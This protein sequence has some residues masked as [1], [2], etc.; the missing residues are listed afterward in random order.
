MSE[1][2]KPVILVAL[3]VTFFAQVALADGDRLVIQVRTDATPGVHFDSI[4]SVLFDTDGSTVLDTEDHTAASARDYG[5]GVRV[6]EFLFGSGIDS[7][8]YFGQTSLQ[9]FGGTVVQRP[10]RV[11]LLPRHGHAVT[12]HN[13]T[14]HVATILL[15]LFFAPVEL[16]VKVVTLKEDNDTSGT[17]SPGDVLEY[18][19]SFTTSHALGRGSVLRDEPA[20]HA[21]LIPGTVTTSHG[22]VFRGNLPS[23]TDVEARFGPVPTGQLVFVKYRVSVSCLSP[24]IINQG[25]LTLKLAGD[26]A[27]Y[28]LLTDDLFTP[29]VNDPTVVPVDCGLP[30]PLPGPPVPVVSPQVSP[31]HAMSS[32]IIE[33]EGLGTLSGPPMFTVNG[34]SVETEVLPSFEQKEFVAALLTSD[35]TEGAGVIP[36]TLTPADPQLPKVHGLIEIRLALE[37][38]KEILQQLSETIADHIDHGLGERVAAFQ[39]TRS[40]AHMDPNSCQPL[41]A[42]L[43]SDLQFVASRIGLQMIDAGDT[44]YQQAVAANATQDE[45]DEIEKATADG[46]ELLDEMMQELANKVGKV[47]KNG[48]GNGKPKGLI[49][50]EP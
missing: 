26:S 21:P 8:T 37:T 45:L 46:V 2:S 43:V 24:E 19:V 20:P 10:W 29:E 41:K 5:L 17:V 38:P 14:L 3:V 49:C 44:A 34:F 4:R 32:V 12:N 39:Q 48:K 22:T 50:P 16:A 11:T 42:E 7:G 6:A 35:M 13:P 18:T 33:G 9:S 1:Y 47:K 28:G 23:D 25:E 27:E 15:P 31:Q 36:F 40:M 30:D